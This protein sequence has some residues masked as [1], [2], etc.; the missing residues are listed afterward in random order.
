MSPF[1]LQSLV[2]SSEVTVEAYWI[3]CW[4]FQDEQRGLI[5]FLLSAIRLKT[6][7][8]ADKDETRMLSLRPRVESWTAARP[9]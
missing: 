7:L 3:S 9:L 5:I 2:D 4:N 1:T 8:H 6:A